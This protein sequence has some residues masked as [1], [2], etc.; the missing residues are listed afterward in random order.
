V[1]GRTMSTCIGEGTTGTAVAGPQQ[2]ADPFAE[3]VLRIAQ[4]HHHIA[5]VTPHR[6]DGFG[7][8]A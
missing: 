2:A 8:I 3:A 7:Q 6:L 1:R 4:S 5:Q